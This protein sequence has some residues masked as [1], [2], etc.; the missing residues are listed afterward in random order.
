MLLSL[1][2]H[3]MHYPLPLLLRSDF[4]FNSYLIHNLLYFHNFIHSNYN[5]NFHT[6][7]MDLSLLHF[8]LSYYIRFHLLSL[9]LRLVPYDLYSSLHYLYNSSYFT[10]DRLSLHYMFIHYLLYYMFIIMLIFI[11]LHLYCSPT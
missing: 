7:V 1:S 4:T 9:L 5:S 2:S 10:P 6:L 3:F 11:V 8:M